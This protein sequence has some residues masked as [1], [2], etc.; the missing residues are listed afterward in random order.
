M[1]PQRSNSQTQARTVSYDAGLHAHLQRIYNRMTLGVLITAITSYVVAST[2]ALMSFFLASP[3]VYVVMFAPLAVIWF[4][5][6]PAKMS[7]SKLKLSFF[8]ISI[9]YGI[10]FSVIL[11]A[12]AQADIARAFFV[13]TGM[14]AGLSIFG[15]TTKKNLDGV[16][17]FAY[18]GVI[19][20]LVMTLLN[21]FIFK[22]AALFDLIS[23]VGIIAFAGIPAWQT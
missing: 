8:G 3:V 11:L 17:N 21:T 16:R 22:D 12:F 2:P 9:L 19:G 6:N 4:G 20:V 10:S 15:Y 23:A 18:M 14:F 7:S 5:F 1:Q 13:A